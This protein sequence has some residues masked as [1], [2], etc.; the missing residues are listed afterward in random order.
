M[1]WLGPPGGNV[2][3]SLMSNIGGPTYVITNSIAGTSQEGYCDAG[4]GLGVVAPGHE[5]GRVQFVVPSGWEKMDNCELFS[6]LTCATLSSSNSLRPTL[7]RHDRRSITEQPRSDWLH[8]QNHYRFSQ[9]LQFEPSFRHFR[10]PCNGCS[11]HVDQSRR[12]SETH[13]LSPISYCRH[14]PTFFL[15]DFLLLFLSRRQFL[16]SV[17]SSK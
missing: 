8:R 2:A 5:C 3:V 14:W 11:T 12:F 9:F 6:S 13:D 15:V 7:P 1:N 10:Q 17:V 4:Y 16:L